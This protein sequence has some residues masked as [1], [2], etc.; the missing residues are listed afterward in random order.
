MTQVRAVGSG[1]D[2]SFTPIDHSPC[3]AAL[4]PAV[5][6]ALDVHAVM[7]DTL[8]HHAPRLDVIE[9]DVGTVDQSINAGPDLGSGTPDARIVTQQ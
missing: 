8:D 3:A 2:L 5:D 6:V 9:H 7:Q 1:S 4:I